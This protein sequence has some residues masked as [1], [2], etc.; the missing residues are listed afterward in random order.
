MAGQ[1]S[2][3]VPRESHFIGLHET[4]RRESNRAFIYC[5]PERKREP[6]NIVVRLSVPAVVLWYN[7][8]V[9]P[10]HVSSGKFGASSVRHM[11][12]RSRFSR[13]ALP[14]G[15]AFTTYAFNELNV[16]E[17]QLRY[18]LDSPVS[19]RGEPLNGL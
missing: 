16:P 9:T 10:H 11:R 19:A 13:F 7:V 15:S 17:L 2:Q 18:E 6:A 12:S 5:I 3:C 4:P 1:R 8:A 14:R